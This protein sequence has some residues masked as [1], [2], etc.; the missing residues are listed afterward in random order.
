MIILIFIWQS[1]CQR[2]VY[3]QMSGFCR[4]LLEENPELET[5]VLS[6]LQNDEDGNAGDSFLS[7]YGYEAADFVPEMGESGYPLLF[8][9]GL[10]A[11]ISAAVL[12]LT[13]KENQRIRR[14][15]SGMTDYLERIDMG[16]RG[17]DCAIYDGIL[18]PEKED[19][20]THLR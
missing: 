18:L 19:E 11:V 3:T 14:K 15:I 10:T 9:T 8:S 6:A 13:P 7:R 1:A 4:T 20:F 5:E 12:F 2:A 16:A 17:I